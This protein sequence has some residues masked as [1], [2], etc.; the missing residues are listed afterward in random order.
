M[1]LVQI[2]DLINSGEKTTRYVHASVDKTVKCF[3]RLSWKAYHE[4]MIHNSSD[5]SFI[6]L[7]LLL[8][9][10]EVNIHFGGQ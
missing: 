7:I 8:Q 6:L 2:E 10:S 4:I 9:P 3:F 1:V 5:L